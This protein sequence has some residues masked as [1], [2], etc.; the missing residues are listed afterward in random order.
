MGTGIRE[1][2]TAMSHFPYEIHLVSNRYQI[3]YRA[4]VPSEEYFIRMEQKYRLMRLMFAKKLDWREYQKRVEALRIDTAIE[5]QRHI[6]FFKLNHTSA[7]M[8][9]KIFDQ[10]MGR[11]SGI[12][13]LQKAK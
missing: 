9:K 3:Y 4:V 7:R 13:S 8:P 11:F 6:H 12:K 2:T 10:L 1:I 5:C